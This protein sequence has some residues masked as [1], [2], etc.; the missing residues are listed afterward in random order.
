MNGGELLVWAVANRCGETGNS[1]MFVAQRDRRTLLSSRENS[2]SGNELLEMQ[3]H[4]FRC[5][6]IVGAAGPRNEGSSAMLPVT[7]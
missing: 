1:V 3:R 4:Q 2:A 7:H 5:N 6:E